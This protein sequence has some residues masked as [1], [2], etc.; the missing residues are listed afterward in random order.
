[1]IK[2]IEHIQG[3]GRVG[4]WC[5]CWLNQILWYI[6]EGKLCTALVSE[7]NYQAATWGSCGEDFVAF[8]WD[9]INKRQLTWCPI[10]CEGWL[11]KKDCY[12]PVFYTR[13]DAEAEMK[14][15]ANV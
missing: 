4:L 11:D 14:G 10:H 2:P 6:H 7:I 8:G 3:E 1:M 9:S 12:V 15:E 5:P 13:A